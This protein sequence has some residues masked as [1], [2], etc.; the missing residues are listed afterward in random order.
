[1]KKIIAKIV[2]IQMILNLFACSNGIKQSEVICEY[3]SYNCLYYAKETFQKYKYSDYIFD[4]ISNG[5]YRANTPSVADYRSEGSDFDF[6]VEA[7]VNDKMEYDIKVGM[8]EKYK[9]KIDEMCKSVQEDYFV[10]KK[11]QVYFYD[12]ANNTHTL[13]YE[14]EATNISYDDELPTI[15]FDIVVDGENEDAK[16]IEGRKMMLSDIIVANSSLDG[17]MKIILSAGKK[18]VKFLMEQRIE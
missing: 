2:L 14:G 16:S 6:D 7:Y 4:D 3:K 11:S 1:M 15:M 17:Y 18:R 13:L 10:Q 9:S 5:A 12:K 8:V